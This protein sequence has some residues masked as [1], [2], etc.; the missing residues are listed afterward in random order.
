MK[1]KNN[2]LTI[3]GVETIITLI[4]LGTFGSVKAYQNSSLITQYFN[5]EDT[6]LV[7]AKDEEGKE[8]FKADYSDMKKLQEDETL[9]A[10]QCQAE[11]SVLLNNTNLPLKGGKKVTLLG[12]GSADSAFY[13]GGGG[14]AAIDASKKP[15]LQSVFETQGF[16]LNPVM[17]DFYEEE[18]KTTRNSGKNVVGEAPQSA[19]T[20]TQIDSYKQYNDAA[21]VIF[22]RLGQEGSDVQLATKED[23]TKNMLQFSKNELDLLDSAI[24]NFGREKVVVILNTMN[25]MECGPLLERNVTVLWV[26]AGGEQGLRA[27]PKLLDGTYNPSGKLVDTYCYDNFAHPSMQNFGNFEF[28]NV[29]DKYRK[30]YY[31]YAENIYIGYKYFETR[32][33]DKVMGIGNAGN[34]DYDSTVTFPFGYGLSYTTFDYSNMQMIEEKD[35]FIFK[36]KVTNTGNVDGKEAV[37]L[38]M[39]SPYTQYDIDN[40][41]EKSAVELVGFAKTQIIKPGNSDTVTISVPKEYMR[42]YDAYGEKTYVVDKGD[43]M[44]TAARDAHAATNNILTA[45]GYKIDDGMSYDGVSSLVKTYTQKEFDAKTYSIGENGENIT[46]EFDDAP[47]TYFDSSFTYLTRSNWEGTYPAPLGGSSH[48]I[49]ASTKLIEALAPEVIVEDKEL[50]KPTTGAQNGL[51]LA[52]LIGASYDS[53]YWDLLLD[54]MTPSEMNLLV[55]SGGFA[56]EYIKS[57]QKPT[58][59]EKDGPAGVASTLIGGVGCFGYPIPTVMAST[60]NIELEQQLGRFYGNDALLSKIPGVYAP[61]VNQHRTPFSGR[62]FEYFSED[63]FQSG[64]F[65][66]AMTKELNKYGVYAYT[67]HFALNDQELN[68]DC[69]AT[70]ATEQSIR[71]IYFRTFEIAVRDGDARGIMTGKNRIGAIWN[72]CHKRALTNVLRGEWGFVGHVVTDHTTSDAP[73]F[74]A[75]IAIHNGLDLY[76]AT[77]GTYDYENYETSAQAQWDLRRACH[78]ILYNVAN[79]NVMNYIGANTKVVK[80]TPPWKKT[81]IIVDVVG[82]AS[83]ITLGGFLVGK[84]KRNNKREVKN[85]AI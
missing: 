38:Y 85:N 74:A 65:A 80:V 20:S 72:G 33:A 71:E 11:G 21:I 24:K 76:H 58:T 18:G 37:E 4:A 3:L 46:N 15:S 78:N 13:A 69:A 27:I 44:F 62:N 8:Y 1:L 63:S 10:E 5:Q 6:K 31:N 19:Y 35:N 22:G 56:T 41:I 51:T 2:G 55:S 14:S 43:Y 29:S 67:K 84:S 53:P 57:I 45:K 59:F 17:L 83:L 79:S 47:Y 7:Q 54:Q 75:K 30:Y 52:S 34:F 36:I 49:E 28:S 81:L 9:F 61:S 16:E 50:E 23:A 42:T 12:S 82:L 32:Y 73:D 77:K 60:W 40:K 66:A 25:P 68:R 70:F 26:G 64:I 39:S 48:K